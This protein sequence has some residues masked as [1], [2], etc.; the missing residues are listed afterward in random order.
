MTMS[1]TVRVASHPA[2]ARWDPVDCD[3]FYT[4]DLTVAELAAA[5]AK[6]RQ[7]RRDH[8]D[9]SVSAARVIAVYSASSARPSRWFDNRLVGR[10]PW[11]RVS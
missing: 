1:D 2:G 5:R 3:G 9:R 4:W 7:V 10:R 8:A 11:Q 6:Y